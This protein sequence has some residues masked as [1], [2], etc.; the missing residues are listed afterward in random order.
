MLASLPKQLGLVL[1]GETEMT[2]SDA[3]LAFALGKLASISFL[4]GTYQ[5]E[6]RRLKRSKERARLDRCINEVRKIIGETGPNGQ[7]I[8]RKFLEPSQVK[9]LDARLTALGTSSRRR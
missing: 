6:S 3:D 9:A 2:E 7:P 8:W 1:T 5:A 4:M